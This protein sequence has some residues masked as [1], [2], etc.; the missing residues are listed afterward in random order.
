L[1]RASGHVIQE[2]KGKKEW[3]EGKKE[4]ETKR[5]ERKAETKNVSVTSCIIMSIGDIYGARPDPSS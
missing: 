5:E 2:G 1:E 3:E 4:Q